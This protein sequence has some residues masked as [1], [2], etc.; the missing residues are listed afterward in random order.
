MT[1][2]VFQLISMIKPIINDIMFEE[3]EAFAGEEWQIKTHAIKCK[4]CKRTV[5]VCH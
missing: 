5:R 2:M 4:L 3:E 1:R